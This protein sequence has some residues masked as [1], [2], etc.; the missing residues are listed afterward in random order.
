MSFADFIKSKTKNPTG[1]A[2]PTS[3]VPAPAPTTPPAPTIQKVAYPPQPSQ[4]ERVNQYYNSVIGTEKKATPES[5]KPQPAPSPKQIE[6]Q[7]R[8]KNITQE[9]MSL[10]P[11]LRG[12]RLVNQI[13]YLK[14]KIQPQNGNKKWI[15]NQ[16]KIYYDMLS[17]ETV[18]QIINGDTSDVDSYVQSAYDSV[19]GWKGFLKQEATPTP[20]PTST[21]T[22]TQEQTMSPQNMLAQVFKDYMTVNDSITNNTLP[23]ELIQQIKDKAKTDS[24]QAL[25]SIDDRT[26]QVLGEQGAAMAR[27]DVDRDVAKKAI[28][29]DAFSKFLATRQNMANRGLLNSGFTS[30]ALAR[31]DMA[32]GEQL[33]RLFSG[34][35]ADKSKVQSQYTNTLN[36]LNTQRTNFS[37]EAVE[38]SLTDA[39][40]KANKD[41][42]T[43]KLQSL[44]NVLE[45]LLKYSY[46]TPDAQLK[47]ET[48]LELQN[49][50]NDVAFKQL[51]VKVRQAAIDFVTKYDLKRAQIFGTD[52]VTGQPTLDAQKAASAI[53]QKQVQ[54]GMLQERI[55]QGNTRIAIQQGNLDARIKEMVNRNDRFIQT[56]EA[57][58]LRNQLNALQNNSRILSSQAIEYMRGYNTQADKNA[59]QMYLNYL[60]Q[61]LL[62]IETN[63]EVIDA[64]LY[65]SGE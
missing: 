63:N 36:D 52:P 9:Y 47:S 20:T 40:V 62:Q 57:G 29:R 2:Q 13:K 56:M 8:M 12:K 37:P 26:K 7:E 27:M 21:P 17:P 49:M 55:N 16:L 48:A 19:G 10:D 4:G 34:Y 59:K 15:E 35:G 44:D 53:Y 50:K 33:A 60:D 14:N 64:L 3:T 22:P 31:V 32:T 23:P 51:D 65:P 43:A 28:E 24:E 18:A 39:Y 30:D 11:E 25:K 45:S 54:T 41:T 46:T 5:A 38:K 42:N 6:E 58:A 1:V 61:T